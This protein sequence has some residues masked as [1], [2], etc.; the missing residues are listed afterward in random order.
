MTTS[1]RR[2]GS[3]GSTS[4]LPSVFRYPLRAAFTLPAPQPT[5]EVSERLLNVPVLSL[6][7]VGADRSYR[8]QRTF[9]PSWL[10]TPRSPRHPFSATM[11]CSR[12]LTTKDGS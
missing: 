8:F 2:R 7:R 12:V 1:A 4:G 10:R 9:E 6:L 11:S 5:S 3:L